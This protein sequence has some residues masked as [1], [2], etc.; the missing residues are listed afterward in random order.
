MLSVTEK[1][2]DINFT[3]VS[4]EKNKC[5]KNLIIKHQNKRPKIIS[6]TIINSGY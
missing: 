6:K 4:F 2:L 3:F 1:K 5:K